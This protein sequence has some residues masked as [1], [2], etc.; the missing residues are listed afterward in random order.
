M[1]DTENDNGNRNR[2]MDDR[3][4]VLYELGRLAGLTDNMKADILKMHIEYITELEKLK[5]VILA[6]G[7]KY[8]FVGVLA[9]AIPVATYIGF[10]L[11][12]S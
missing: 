2:W 6:Q 10:K 1:A 3:K 4:H 7:I 9:G 8:G 5:G 12:H 11:L